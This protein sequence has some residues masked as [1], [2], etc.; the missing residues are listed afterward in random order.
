MLELKVG[1]LV[2]VSKYH[3]CSGTRRLYLAEVVAL[4]KHNNNVM[5][6]WTT[7]GE[8]WSKDTVFIKNIAL[9]K[10]GKEMMVMR[11]KFTKASRSDFPV[12]A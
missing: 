4:S 5:V 8:Y 1:Q 6:K 10:P 2:K 9:I 3:S 7:K 11:A 12:K